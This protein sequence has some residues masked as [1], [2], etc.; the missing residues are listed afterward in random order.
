VNVRPAVIS[1]EG[2]EVGAQ[3]KGRFPV[4]KLRHEQAS[5]SMTGHVT[6]DLISTSE[7]IPTKE[8]CPEFILNAKILQTNELRILARLQNA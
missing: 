3:D 4:L 5:T 7:S 6:W 8:S 2:A 1:C